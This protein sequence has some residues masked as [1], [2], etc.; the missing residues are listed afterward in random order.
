MADEERNMHVRDL[1]TVTYPE[2]DNVDPIFL[3]S[4]WE[5]N[6]SEY[7]QVTENKNLFINTV[8]GKN[9]APPL[10]H[11]ITNPRAPSLTLQG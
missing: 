2:T 5:L 9:P 8:G 6:P 4:P 1:V 11:N 10:A 7:L 3:H